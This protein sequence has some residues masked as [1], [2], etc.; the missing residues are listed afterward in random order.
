MLPRGSSLPPWLMPLAGLF[1][2]N[3]RDPK[4]MGFQQPVPI[5]WM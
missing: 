2:T 3:V 5:S 1:R 4:E